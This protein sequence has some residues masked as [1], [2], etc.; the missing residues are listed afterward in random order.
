MMR[1][2]TDGVHW[3]G[4]GGP[5]DLSNIE[6]STFAK[7]LRDTVD[8]TSD[9]TFE[10]LQGAAAARRGAGASGWHLYNFMLPELVEQPTP[11]LDE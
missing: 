10:K 8:E 9:M 2:L 5:D 3:R 11:F 4:I 6:R 1:T 7:T